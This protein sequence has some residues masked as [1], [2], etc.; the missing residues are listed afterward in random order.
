MGAMILGP[1]LAASKTKAEQRLASVDAT[2]AGLGRQLAAALT[3]PGTA[4]GERRERG[5]G[6][7]RFDAQL[8]P[9]GPDPAARRAE[10]DRRVRAKEFGGWLPVRRP[11]YLRAAVSYVT[12]AS[13]YS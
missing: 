8:I 10:L 4:I 5:E 2:G 12:A 3:E 11:S 9:P 13:R 7:V 1:A 6:E